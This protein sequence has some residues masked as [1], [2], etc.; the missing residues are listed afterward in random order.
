MLLL[1]NKTETKT[2][3]TFVQGDVSI[4][5]KLDLRGAGKHIFVNNT[6]LIVH[7]I[8]RFNVTV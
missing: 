2:I 7:V 3:K 6:L 5:L 8:A 1:R 4:P